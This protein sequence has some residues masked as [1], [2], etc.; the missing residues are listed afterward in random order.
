MPQ[1]TSPFWMGSGDPATT[2][3]CHLPVAFSPPTKTLNAEFLLVWA[4]G[5]GLQ[6][7]A[8]HNMSW[9]SGHDTRR[10]RAWV[11]WMTENPDVREWV[12]SP[13]FLRAP[14]TWPF[15]TGF[16]VTP[17]EFACGYG[18][19]IAN[20]MPTNPPTTRMGFVALCGYAAGLPW[21]FASRA[22]DVPEGLLFRYA[23]DAAE[24]LRDFPLFV[25]W[26]NNTDPD[27]LLM[28][29]DISAPLRQRLVKHANL[30][31]PVLS[32]RAADVT[33]LQ[34]R[35]IIWNAIVRGLG[36]RPGVQLVRSYIRRPLGTPQHPRRVLTVSEQRVGRRQIVYRDGLGFHRTGQL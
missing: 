36:A 11:R 31:Q 19:Q 4:C 33:F 23:Q 2:I 28:P 24:V 21:S 14:M 13:S 10:T 32:L 15:P 5:E 26:Q 16:Q 35:A 3:L 1:Q 20:R 25:L 6:T 17:W 8:P 7:E 12:E 30:K 27:V 18:A 34:E 9:P 22:F 29:K